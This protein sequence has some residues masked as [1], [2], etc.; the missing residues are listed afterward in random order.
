M[1]VVISRDLHAVSNVNENQR[2]LSE[3]F[4]APASVFF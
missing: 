2:G 3:A 4:A 1:F